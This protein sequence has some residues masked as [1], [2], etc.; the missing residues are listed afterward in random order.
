MPRMCCNYAQAPYEEMAEKE[1][2]RYKRQ[3]EQVSATR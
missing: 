2:D 3:K 1:K